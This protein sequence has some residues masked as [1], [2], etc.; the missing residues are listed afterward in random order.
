MTERLLQVL[1]ARMNHRGQAMAREA[2]LREI[3]GVDSET[4]AR[5]VGKLA[6]SGLTEIVSPLPFLV[7][8]LR[9]WSGSKLDRIDFKQQSKRRSPIPLRGPVSSIAA[10]AKQQRVGGAGEGEALLAEVLETLGPEADREVFRGILTAHS[11]V[12]IR[13]VLARVRA[14]KVIRVSRSALFRALLTKLSH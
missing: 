1:K 14:T 6:A 9:S 8:K 11:P 7:V 3:L 13:R 2:D 4:L 10:A 12:L 5:E